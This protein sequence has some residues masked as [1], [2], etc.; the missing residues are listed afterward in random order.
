[1]KDDLPLMSAEFVI[2]GMAFDP[3]ECTL[4]FGVQPTKVLVE[5]DRVPGTRRLV[6][7]SA[8]KV[9]SKRE[10]CDSTDRAIWPVVNSVWPKRKEIREFAGE[11]GLRISFIVKILG[12]LG[13]RNFL[14]EFSPCLLERIAYFRA[15]LHIDVY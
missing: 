13:K 14:Y 11:K 10:R 8:W 15:P 6:P 1:M 4:H 7:Q 3:N 12:G 2:V 5:G 9:E